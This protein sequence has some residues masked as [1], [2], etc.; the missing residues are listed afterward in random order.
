VV[1]TAAAVVVPPRPVSGAGLG[2]LCASVAPAVADTLLPTFVVIGVVVMA[3]L[4]PLCAAGAWVVS[5]V[6]SRPRVALGGAEPARTPTTIYVALG[7]LYLHTLVLAWTSLWSGPFDLLQVATALLAL[8]S[9]LLAALVL[10]LRT[11]RRQGLP[12]AYRRLP[13]VLLAG[14]W[15]LYAV[16]PGFLFSQPVIDASFRWVAGDEIQAWATNLLRRPEEQIPRSPR[17]HQ[18]IASIALPDLLRRPSRLL[19]M[20]PTDRVYLESGPSQDRWIR[21]EWGGG[22]GHWG[23]L[24]GAR[25]A[26]TA[27]NVSTDGLTSR[28]LWDGVYYW[29]EE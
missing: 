18:R 12:R 11:L 27:P 21:I 8:L 22:F 9:G 20:L 1:L 4:A 2:V 29:S 15:G 23:L 28:R 17:D 26:K 5:R 7:G 25:A 6:L 16:S 19:P 14:L 24:V 3:V 10:L 13:T